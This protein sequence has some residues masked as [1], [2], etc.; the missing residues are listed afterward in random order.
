MMGSREMA[1]AAMPPSDD[2]HAIPTG[3][4]GAVG[5]RPII[6]PLTN[7]QLVAEIDAVSKP[8]T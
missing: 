7:P 1:M 6:G 4:D 8:G 5:L 3:A 2:D